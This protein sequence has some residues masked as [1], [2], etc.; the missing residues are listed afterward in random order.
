MTMTVG[1]KLMPN[2]VGVDIGCGMRLAK[3]KSKKVEFQKLDAVIRENI[4]S[5]FS[6]RDKAHRYADEIDLSR[7]HCY[8][9]IN[10][11]KALCSLGTL[12]GGNHFIEL[13]KDEDGDVYVIIHSGSRHL[14]L[15]VTEYY[16]KKGN[17]VLKARG[18]EVPY[19]LTYLYGELL[20]E[21][22]DDLLIIQEFARLNRA[23]MMDELAKGMKFKFVDEYECIHNYLDPETEIHG[24][25]VKIIRK[26]AISAKEGEKVIIP[27]NMRDGIILATGKGNEEWNCSAPHGAGRIYKRSD[28]KE[29]FTVSDFKKE[30]KGIYSTCVDSSTLDEA[31]FVYRRLEDIQEVIEDTVRIDNILKPI[32]NFKAGGRK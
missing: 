12:G 25:K 23:A 2:I 24:E 13:D 8:K 21:Y 28:V 15:E 32:Y 27:I 19:E 29:R 30:M 18:E 6:I 22:V 26:G 3:L 7:L 11:Q 1:E 14:G 10:E 9:H 20:K 16:I 17:E 4:P 31:P 5:G